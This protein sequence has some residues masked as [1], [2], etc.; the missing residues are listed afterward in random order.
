[1]NKIRGVKNSIMNEEKKL[2]EI[3][4]LSIIIGGKSGV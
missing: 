1:M 3:K 4:H 2:C